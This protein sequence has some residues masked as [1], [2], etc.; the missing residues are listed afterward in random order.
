MWNSDGIQTR[1]CELRWSVQ[2][3]RQVLI[4]PNTSSH[5]PGSLTNCYLYCVFGPS[6]ILHP[7]HFELR[8]L[9]HM[10]GGCLQ[11]IRQTLLNAIV[12]QVYSVKTGNKL[13]RWSSAFTVFSHQ[14]EIMLVF[15]HAP[16]KLAKKGS[17]A[18]NS[19]HWLS[20]LLCLARLK[21]N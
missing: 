11:L 12:Q 6:I 16:F 8:F 2:L 13:L 20:Q 1:T 7:C 15:E 9:L 21:S 18:P 4:S 19:W 3:F 10:L 5:G 17:Y 14:T